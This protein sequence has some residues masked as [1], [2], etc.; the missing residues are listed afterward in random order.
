[1]FPRCVHLPTFI[2][3]LFAPF[4]LILIPKLRRSLLVLLWFQIGLCQFCSQRHF[5]SQYSPPSTSPKLPG[6][7]CNPLHNQLHLSSQLTSLASD[8]ATNRLQIG[9]FCPPFTPQCMSSIFII[10]IATI[11]SNTSAPVYL[12]QSSHS[13]PCQ[14]CPCLSWLSACWPLDLEP[15]PSSSEIY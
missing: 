9:H 1:M 13:T 4:V 5:L 7:S 10:F 15:P 6:A 11:Y 8:S 14:H 12:T 2:S 3:V